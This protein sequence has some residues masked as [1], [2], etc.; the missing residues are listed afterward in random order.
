MQAQSL[1][2]CQEVTVHRDEVGVRALAY[3]LPRWLHRLLAALPA[4]VLDGGAALVERA[5]S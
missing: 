4:P 2:F 3:C 5:L 1:F